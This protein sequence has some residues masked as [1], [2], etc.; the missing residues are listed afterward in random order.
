MPRIIAC[1][2]GFA[3]LL[4]GAAPASAARGDFPDDHPPAGV[5]GELVHATGEVMLSYRYGHVDREGLLDGRERAST[6]ETFALGYKSAPQEATE[7]VHLFEAMWS[8]LEELTLVLALPF[9]VKEMELLSQVTGE[10]YSTRASGFGDISLSSLYHVYETSRSRVHL[11]LGLS[12]PT[13]STNTN[14]IT[15]YSNGMRERLPY[16]MQLGTGTVDLTAGFTYSGHWKSNTW[17]SQILGIVRA[18][19]NTRGYSQGNAYSLTGWFGRRWVSWLHTSFR[20]DW[21][22]WFD[23]N[24]VDSRLDAT[25]SPAHDPDLQS[26]RRLDALFGVDLYPGGELLRG[27]SLA[28][29][30]GLPVYQHLDGPQ[31]RTRWLLTFAIQYAF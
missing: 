16:S 23:P 14:D 17:G 20:L 26:G 9:V 25:E 3:L 22:Q 5:L 30:A 7:D 24:G 18:G 31:L 28:I 10:R 27:A 29:E 11:N 13:G 2:I 8:P 4:G 12:F 19:T 1:L 6:A 21:R 15:P